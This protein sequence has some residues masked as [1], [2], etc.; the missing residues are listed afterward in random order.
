MAIPVISIEVLKYFRPIISFIF[1]FVV[2]FAILEKSKALGKDKQNLNSLIALVIAFIVLLTP[3]LVK[4][5]EFMVGPFVVLFF[6]I[7]FMVVIFLFMGVSAEDVGK[8]FNTSAMFSTLLV[9]SIIILIFAF[10]NAYGDVI[11][12]I[13]AGEPGAG[14]LGVTAGKI[15]FNPKILG[16]A[17]LLLVASQAMRLL[18]SSK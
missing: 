14:G 5:I 18:A 16:A 10:S 15:L 1:I 6:F 13:T 9:I 11:Q 2:I 12:G 8:F 4:L 3:G 7:L 17:F